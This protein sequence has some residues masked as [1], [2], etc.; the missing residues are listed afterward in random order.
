M[1]R[2][3]LRSRLNACTQASLQDVFNVTDS[4]RA[5]NFADDVD[6]ATE[7]QLLQRRVQTPATRNVLNVCVRDFPVAWFIELEVLV[8]N[9]PVS[10]VLHPHGSA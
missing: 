10:C 6:N 5:L 8:D 9:S 1:S 3:C 7:Q 4:V 2:R